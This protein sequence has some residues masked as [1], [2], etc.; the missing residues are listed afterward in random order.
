MQILS[1]LGDKTEYTWAQSLRFFLIG[2]L[3]AVAAS[4]PPVLWA[5]W[6][7]YQNYT[8]PIDWSLIEGMALAAIGPALAGY[9]LSHRNLLK[10]PP[11]LDIPPEFRPS[12]TTVVRSEH[13][14]VV[15]AETDKGKVTTELSPHT[16][17][18]V[19]EMTGTGDGTGTGTKAPDAKPVE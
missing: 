5:I 6:H 17:T 1:A 16:S 13:S 18:R 15:T 4:L 9:W 3:W 14:T 11:W 10:V 7:N 12:K 2:A 8:D 19:I